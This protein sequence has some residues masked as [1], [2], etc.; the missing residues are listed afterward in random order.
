MGSSL[1]EDA[2]GKKRIVLNDQASEQMISEVN[3]NQ[4]LS[5]RDIEENKK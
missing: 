2:D 1:A 5:I 3:K 4:F